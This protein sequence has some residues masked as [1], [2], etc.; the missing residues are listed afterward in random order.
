MISLKKT[1][2]SSCLLQT[3]IRWSEIYMLNCNTMVVIFFPICIGCY[4]HLICNLKRYSMLV[5]VTKI[6]SNFVLLYFRILLELRDSLVLLG[7]ARKAY[8]NLCKI[9][10]LK[11]NSYEFQKL[12]NL[13]L[14][15]KRQK[16]WWLV[17]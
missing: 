13:F 16:K 8:G 3:N 14:F 5:M 15:V 11:I 9:I 10:N 17:L 4:L 6:V 1:N 7:R 12:N 2:W